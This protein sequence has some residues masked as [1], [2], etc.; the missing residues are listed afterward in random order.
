MHE[1]SRT[2]FDR[3]R[4]GGL[5]R[6]LALGGV[7]WGLQGWALAADGTAFANEP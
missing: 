5:I 3:L 7:L 4:E 1:P 2:T 6:K